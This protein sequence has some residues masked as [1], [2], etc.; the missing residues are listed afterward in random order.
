MIFV[1][2]HANDKSERM[3]TGGAFA[4]SSRGQRPGISI[5]DS[6]L[7]NAESVLTRFT[8]PFRVHVL[9]FNSSVTQGVALG[10]N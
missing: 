5:H 10:W 8:N 3:G 1:G 2:A 4:N 7:T 6:Y 9:L